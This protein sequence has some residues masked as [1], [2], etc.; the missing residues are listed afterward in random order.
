MIFKSL[1][2]KKIRIKT[3]F[4]ELK[5]IQRLKVRWGRAPPPLCGRPWMWTIVSKNKFDIFKRTKNQ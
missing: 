5:K 4:F 3:I 1:K 2:K